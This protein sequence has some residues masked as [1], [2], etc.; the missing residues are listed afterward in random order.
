MHVSSCFSS[1]LVCLAFAV[2]HEATAQSDCP[3]GPFLCVQVGTPTGKPK[4]KPKPPPAPFKPGS[5]IFE[6]TVDSKQ[7]SK[8]LQ[9]L[10][11]DH[12]N[13]TS[14]KSDEKKNFR[15]WL[16]DE[17]SNIDSAKTYYLLLNNAKGAVVKG[18]ELRP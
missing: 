4:P 6:I 17:A 14:L 18:S 16:G 13:L 12:P 5:P 1:V 8:T 3:P 9:Q 15:D 10:L 2:A 7:T 11:N